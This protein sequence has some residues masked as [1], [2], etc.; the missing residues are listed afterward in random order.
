MGER[1][2]DKVCIITG[3][4]RGIGRAC[5]LAFA[6]E[7]AIVVV[8]DVDAANVTETVRHIKDLGGR[9]FGRPA[10]VTSA[11]EVRRLVQGTADEHGKL[12]V[13]FNNAGGGRPQPTHEMTID[14]YRKTIA[15]NL[16]G[17][18]YGVYAAL[19]LMMRQRHGVILTTSS[20]AGLNAVLGLTA[21]GAAKAAVIMM[22][23]NI[24]IEYGKWGIRAN[25]ISPGL[26]D[27]PGMRSYVDTLPGGADEVTGRIPSGRLGLGPD[28]AATAVFLASDESAY[29]NGVVIPVDGGVQAKMFSP[30]LQQQ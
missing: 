4:G 24:A 1:L 21:Y 29:I 7:G 20:G 25:A 30:I 26:M 15:L 16:D 14:E 2:T 19:P 8:N 17:V 12:D 3:A 11:E 13:L 6:A 23:Q 10:D 22:M 27:T 18:F 28:I 5:A 9:A